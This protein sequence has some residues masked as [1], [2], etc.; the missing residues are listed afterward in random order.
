[1]IVKW[2]SR[3]SCDLCGFD[4]DELRVYP[5]D[6]W[7]PDE[8]ICKACFAGRDSENSFT[9]FELAQKAAEL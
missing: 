3:L 8:I 4:H 1:M 2:E 9:D 5:N 7:A 6:A